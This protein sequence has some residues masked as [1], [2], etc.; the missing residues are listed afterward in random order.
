MLTLCEDQKRKKEK[1][2]SEMANLRILFCSYLA[3][4]S[5]VGCKTNDGLAPNGTSS[6]E[7]SS[8]FSNGKYDVQLRV[9]TLEKTIGVLPFVMRSAVDRPQSSAPA[10]NKSLAQDY[11]GGSYQANIFGSR[12]VIYA[13]YDDLPAAIRDGFKKRAD[14]QAFDAV[15]HSPLIYKIIA[16]VR[17][18]FLESEKRGD[19][20]DL[21]AK[22]VASEAVKLVLSS[23]KEIEDIIIKSVD[24]VGLREKFD[25]KE[26]KAN[27][28][29]GGNVL[30]ETKA[31]PE[32]LAFY[33]GQ[34]NEINKLLDQ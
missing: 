17:Q 13:T 8:F 34:V 16:G 22:V 3:L 9:I 10:L 23:Q 28:T 33:D 26:L 25:T 20:L 30:K 18:K 11:T 12:T 29:K 21:I 7:I 15:T 5:M 2:R 6:S 1:G 14:S 24:V 31:F 4:V 27:L 19:S 32:L